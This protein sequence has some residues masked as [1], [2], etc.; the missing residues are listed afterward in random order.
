MQQ[1][2]PVKIFFHLKTTIMKKK[3]RK[4]TLNKTTVK[5]LAQNERLAV[6]GLHLGTY[7]FCTKNPTW[8]LTGINC[9]IQP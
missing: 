1:Y 6:G 9:C 8:A 3:Q 2:T 4:L 5:I 7:R